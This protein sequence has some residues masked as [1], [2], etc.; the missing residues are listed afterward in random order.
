MNKNGEC[1]TYRVPEIAEMLGISEKSAYNL[2]NSTPPFKVYR[3]GKSTR[4]NRESFDN[5]FN[6]P[7]A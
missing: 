7:A 3:I 1:K 6:N 4:I 5:W 2:C